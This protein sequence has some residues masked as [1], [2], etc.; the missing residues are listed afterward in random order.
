MALCRKHRAAEFLGFKSAENGPSVQYLLS[1]NLR[2]FG[3]G[4]SIPLEYD[5]AAESGL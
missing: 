1:S 2:R 3:W 4:F 5:A